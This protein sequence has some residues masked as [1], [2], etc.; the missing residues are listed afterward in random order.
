[1]EPSGDQCKCCAL[2][3][4]W[5]TRVGLD[6]GSG[7]DQ[8]GW[9]PFAVKA[10]SRLVEAWRPDVLWTLSALPYTS[11]VVA[12]LVAARKRYNLPWIGEL[13]DLW[14]DF[15]RYDIGRVRQRIERRL[16]RRVL[17]SAAG[18]VTVSEPMAA[19]LS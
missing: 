5:S 17:S 12:H 10:G 16:E 19:R 13:R 18:L 4:E 11:L 6:F 3:I 9:L 7:S 15:H 2:S 1:M 8:I 14:V